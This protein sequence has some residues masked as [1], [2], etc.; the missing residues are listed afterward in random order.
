MEREND[1]FRFGHEFLKGLTGNPHRLR[2][3]T[4]IFTF[5]VIDTF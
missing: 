3:G 4:E 1:E 2:G 5:V